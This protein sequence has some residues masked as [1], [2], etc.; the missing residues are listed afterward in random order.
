MHDF[1]KW[2][3]GA[4]GRLREMLQGD[5]DEALLDEC[6]AELEKANPE[7]YYEF[8]G[9]PEGPLEFIISASARPELF[10]AVDA[11][12]AEAPAIEGWQW[13]ALKPAQ[14]F[15]FQSEWDGL[16]LDPEAMWFLPMENDAGH[17]GLCVSMEGL[18]QEQLE[19]FVGGAWIVMET[20]AGERALGEQVF[21]Y[22]VG[23]LPEDPDGE[24]WIELVDLPK[25]LEWRKQGS[26]ADAS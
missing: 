24:G 5:R 1:W 10:E 11:L 23:T 2:F 20:G 8:G 21:H 12:I 3:S 26:G 4:E 9:E 22:E 15:D 19:T 18:K 17:L 13:L 25:Y 7:L 14:G 16:H 6:Q